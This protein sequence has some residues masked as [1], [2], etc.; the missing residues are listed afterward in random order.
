MAARARYVTKKGGTS[1]PARPRATGQLLPPSAPQAPPLAALGGWLWVCWWAISSD[2]EKG[3]VCCLRAG[4][5]GS[6]S[7]CWR[8]GGWCPASGGRPRCRSG[9]GREGST[10][11]ATPPK[12]LRCPSAPAPLGAAA[13]WVTFGPRGVRLVELG[14]LAAGS[15]RKK[16][17]N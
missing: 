11:D 10:P 1:R 16:L 2:S 6:R 7:A 8:S 9:G 12:P 3:R 13:A 4:P 15:C 14:Q 5:V 17:Y